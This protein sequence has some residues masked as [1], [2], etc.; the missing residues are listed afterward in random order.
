VPQSL[1]QGEL[2]PVGL[3][4]HQRLVAATKLLRANPRY[5][6]YA[7]ARLSSTLGT[8]VASLGLAFAVIGA[9]GGAAALGVVM[10]SGLAV[11]IAVPPVAGVLADRLP[12][13]SIIVVCQMLCG[14][15]QL[16][17]AGLVLTGTASAP[18]ALAGLAILSG[19]AEAFFQPAV[20]GL[21]PQRV[22]AQALVPANALLQI[23][24][25]AVA[26]AGPPLAGLVIV[27]SS[28]GG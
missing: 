25:N 12:R 13:V 3:M 15:C 10:M 27:A 26:I 24:N 19:A 21:V 11:F 17:S 9:G 23:A 8:T 6:R 22:P 16:A 2:T 5:R 18:A 28:P 20:K 1:E 7:V 4:M 14:L